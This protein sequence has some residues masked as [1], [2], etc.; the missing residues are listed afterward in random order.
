[1]TARGEVER[2]EGEVRSVSAE[3]LAAPPLLGFH[4]GLVA[5]TKRVKGRVA[6]SPPIAMAHEEP[7]CTPE[8]S[9]SD[10]LRF[11]HE[12]SIVSQLITS[13]AELEHYASALGI[14]YSKAQPISVPLK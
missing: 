13:L 10:P 5:R 9:V 2:A 4:S 1:M 7:S 14:F 12:E 6:S 11:S 8:E 3:G